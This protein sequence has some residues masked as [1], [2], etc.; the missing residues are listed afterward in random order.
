[1]VHRQNDRAPPQRAQERG[2]YGILD[3][4][5]RSLSSRDLNMLEDDRTPSSQPGSAHKCEPPVRDD[6]ARKSARV[7]LAQKQTHSRPEPRKLRLEQIRP[8][9]IG[10]SG[11]LHDRAARRR[12]TS[13]EQLR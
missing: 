3:S 5:G 1:M 9:P 11:A 7:R 6:P 13:H 2:V 4:G 8:Q 12:I 10:H